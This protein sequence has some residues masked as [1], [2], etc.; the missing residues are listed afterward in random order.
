MPPPS[1]AWKTRTPP[2]SFQ[3]Q[4]V[5]FWMRLF[6][7]QLEA[8]CLQLSFSTYSCVLELFCLQLIFFAYSGKVRVISTL[9]DCKQ[10]SS[11][12]SQKAPTVNKLPSQS[13]CTLFLAC[14]MQRRVGGTYLQFASSGL[15][16]K[17]CRSRENEGMNIIK[18]PEGAGKLGSRTLSKIVLESFRRV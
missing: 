15:R 11:T 17:F 7:L 8:P 12:V 6:C 13:L 2:D 10:R 16:I 9:T 18:P 5:N 3:T 14:R 4:T 1:L